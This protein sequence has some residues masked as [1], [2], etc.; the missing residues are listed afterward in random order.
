MR[1]RASQVF[2]FNRYKETYFLFALLD[3]CKYLL[4]LRCKQKSQCRLDKT[5]VCRLKVPSI[6]PRKTSR[7]ASHSLI[8]LQRMTAMTAFFCSSFFSS[9]DQ[10]RHQVDRDLHRICVKQRLCLHE[11][12]RR[13]PGGCEIVH[14]V[15]SR[16]A[17]PGRRAGGDLR[18]VVPHGE[19]DH[20]RLG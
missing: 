8:D 3:G 20:P 10:L 15:I 7:F 9:G 4:Q 12:E 13:C 18:Q 1:T 17:R 14:G 5:R 6:S 2:P 16:P 19:H 11:P